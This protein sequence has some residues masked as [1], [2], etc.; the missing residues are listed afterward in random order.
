MKSAVE[1]KSQ[2][3]EHTGEIDLP[4]VGSISRIIRIGG[5][6]LGLIMVIVGLSADL[7]GVG[8]PGS[9][10]TGQILMIVFGM[11]ALFVGALGA[12]S[13][14]VY[15]SG[16]VILM[17]TLLL[18]AGLELVAII[19]VRSGL[20][21]SPHDE[22]VQRYLDVPYYQS[23]AWSETLWAET[24]R[25]DSYQY[26]PYTIWRHRP[27]SGETVNVD[28]SGR[29]V[30][31]GANC[32]T[33]SY[34]VFAFG[35]ST[36]WGWG[37]PD[38]ATIPAYLQSSLSARRNEPVCVVNFGEDGYIST[39]SV[40]RLKLLLQSGLIPDSVLFYSGVN[41]VYSGYI[42]G[43]AG[44]P[45]IIEDLESRFEGRGHP[46]V[47]WLEASR[48]Y[49]IARRQVQ[50]KSRAQGRH[51]GMDYQDMGIPASN[52]AVRLE[53]VYIQNHSLVQSLAQAYGFDAFFALQPH[54]AI[55]NKALTEAEAEVYSQFDPALIILAEETYRRIRLEALS[56]ETIWY[57]G[58]VLDHEESQIWID[59]WGHITPEGN[60][61]VAEA[62]TDIIQSADSDD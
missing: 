20:I 32:D 44:V 42:T 30:T 43:R 36:M 35:G 26:E 15:F 52:L 49:G 59:T 25:S 8:D 2:K 5:L 29:R 62:L 28:E 18:L 12:R 57:L 41:D 1:S 13:K 34:D 21:R 19:A 47:K 11:I 7:A 31:S 10:G 3:H 38:W 16:A 56:S 33:H 48:V 58:N 37:A 39:Q 55:G 4:A 46:I 50:A 60:Q 6:L 24:L 14:T 23:R 22:L 17:N 54:M 27:F 9:L 61:L 40:V 45:Y 51:L 53:E